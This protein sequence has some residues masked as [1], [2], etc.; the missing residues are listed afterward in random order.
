MVVLEL[1]TGTLYLLVLA[2]G[3]FAG[4]IATMLG[5]GISAQ[6]LTSALLTMIG[7][8]IL[9][10]RQLAKNLH[11]PAAGRDSAVNL[12]IGATLHIDSWQEGG[13]ASAI[14]RGANWQVLHEDVNASLPEGGNKVIYQ[15]GTFKIVEIVGSRL[16]VAPLA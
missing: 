1:L 8:A 2:L 11:L 16:V 14:Y 10:K 4:A 9:R 7:W 13:T 5:L 12:D 15:P 6:L 3:C